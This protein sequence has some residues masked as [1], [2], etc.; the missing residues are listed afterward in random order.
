MAKSPTTRAPI[1]TKPVATLS[2]FTIAGYLVAFSYVLWPHWA[3]SLPL[4]YQQQLPIVIG[5]VLAAIAG[6]FAP[7]TNRTSTTVDAARI[8]ELETAVAN[9]I[10][11]RGNVHVVA[12]GGEPGGDT[13]FTAPEDPKQRRPG[14]DWPQ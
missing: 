10:Q 11:Q 12:R 3:D 7:H 13:T 2:T 4:A 5:A 9:L 14:S 6:Y 8:S 1:E